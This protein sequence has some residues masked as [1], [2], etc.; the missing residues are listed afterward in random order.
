M[1]KIIM[2]CVALQLA[3]SLQ[4]MQDPNSLG[5]K[6]IIAAK[7]GDFETAQKLL[8]A[9]APVNYENKYGLTALTAA[10]DCNNIDV[11]SL[12]IDRGAQVGLETKQDYFY[13]ALLMAAGNGHFEV[14][15]LLIDRGAQVNQA[16]TKGETALIWAAANHRSEVAR[17]LIDRGAQVNHEDKR[18]YTAFVWAADLGH[19]E[20]AH[21]L[22]DAML[23]PTKEQKDA[24]Y[25]TILSL[26]R[27]AV[28]M[29][30]EM[31]YAIAKQLLSAYKQENKA[32]VLEQINKI[33]NQ[34]RRQE[35]IEYVNEK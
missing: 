22:I 33:P 32:M 5:E 11:V 4:A 29:P 19:L 7:R 12:L 9:G 24:V 23:K 15:R 31:I 28:E 3:G 27:H 30:Q 21:L 2:L 8:D 20:V 10:S 1:K 6:L 13:F 17:L 34:G 14:A 25:E 16:N 26:Q 35:L 18:G